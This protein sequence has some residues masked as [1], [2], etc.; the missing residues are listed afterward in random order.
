MS[1]GPS[2]GAS[3]DATPRE[4]TPLDDQEESEDINRVAT[5]DDEADEELIDV[6]EVED[7]VRDQQTSLPGALLLQVF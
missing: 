2:R 7:E 1:A 3:R 4:S 5:D 6:Q